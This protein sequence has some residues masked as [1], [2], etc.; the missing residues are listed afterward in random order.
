MS[1]PLATYGRIEDSG[2]LTSHQELV[3]LKFEEPGAAP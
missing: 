3:T 1:G 2:E